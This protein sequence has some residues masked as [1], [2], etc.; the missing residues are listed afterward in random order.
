MAS[1]P[2]EL[3]VLQMC[4]YKSQDLLR[5]LERERTTI[6]MSGQR[7]ASATSLSKGNEIVL[8]CDRHNNET[9]NLTNM[10]P[11]SS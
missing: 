10:L 7:I 8:A 9:V 6:G 11:C 3:N 1:V 5:L 2:L 4:N